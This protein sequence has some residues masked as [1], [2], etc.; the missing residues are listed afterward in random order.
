MSVTIAICQTEGRFADP[1]AALDLLA[2]EAA[3]ARA[4]GAG[5]L[6]LPELFLTGYNLGLARAR[7]LSLD[8]AD[9]ALI[10]ARAIARETGIAL[11]LGYPERAGDAV[12]NSALLI[13]ETGMILLNYRKV[14][15][16]GD[17]DRT[18]FSLRGD[19]FPVIPWRGLKLGL[20]ICY[21]IEFPETVRL[22]ALAGADIVLVPTALM[23]PYDVVA[24]SVI[25]A[26]AYESQVYLAYAN[27]CGSEDGL[28]YIGRSSICGPDGQ[29][30]AKAD[31]DPALITAAVDPAHLADVRARDPLLG[32]R[33]PAL[34]RQIGP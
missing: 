19:A 3:A 24:D 12:A 9:A 6:V 31:A 21:D 5:L 16:F 1:S 15:L 13:D 28:A 18:M 26:R 32:D 2:A 25:P 29:V 30:L 14:H 34:Y 17:L 8:H 22:L 7:A 33:R 11:C 20:A 23:P 10:R 27:H 4:K